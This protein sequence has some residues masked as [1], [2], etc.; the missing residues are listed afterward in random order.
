MIGDA[1]G[2]LSGAAVQAGTALFIFT[3]ESRVLFL[4]APF[5]N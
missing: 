2:T 3:K 4:F 5:G 1:G